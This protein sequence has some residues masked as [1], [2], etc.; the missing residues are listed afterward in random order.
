MIRV[1]LVDDEPIVRSGIALL[2]SGEPDI[3]V[4]AD[5]DTG[6]EAVDLAARLHPDVVIAD[7]RMP[8]MDGVETSRRIVHATSGVTGGPA[9]YR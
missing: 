6:A 3:E 7:V 1:I 9:R 8:V 5:V 4:I 2:L